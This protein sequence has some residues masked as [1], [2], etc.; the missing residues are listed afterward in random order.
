MLDIREPLPSEANAL[1]GAAFTAWQRGVGP[2]ISVASRSGICERDFADFIRETPEQ[3]LAAFVAQEAVGFVATEHGDNYISDLW[4]DPVYEGKGIGSAL[5]RT[6][7]DKIRARGYDTAT[8]EVLTG[9]TR[10]LSLYRHLGYGVLWQGM[11]VDGHLD[12]LVEKTG[13]MKSLV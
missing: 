5:L 7:A 11:R 13:M 2:H 3:I 10:A 12:E 9:N 8:I 6:M 1:A 4:V